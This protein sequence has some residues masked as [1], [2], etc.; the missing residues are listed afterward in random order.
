[1]RVS[2]A[3]GDVVSSFNPDV[4]LQY[5]V[6]GVFA[7]LLVWFAKVAYSRETERADRLEAEVIRLNTLIQDKNIP[8][9]VSATNAIRDATEIIRDYE[10]D[11]SRS[12]IPTPT[13]PHRGPAARRGG[14]E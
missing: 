12:Y 2:L 8:A 9:L 14:G 13:A 3:A 11:R 5:G 4:L 10:R 6:L 1:M 7:I